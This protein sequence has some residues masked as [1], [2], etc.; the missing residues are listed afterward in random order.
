MTGNSV[1]SNL[2]TCPCYFIKLGTIGREQRE[3]IRSPLFSS[4]G[5]KDQVAPCVYLHV[6]QELVPLSWKCFVCWVVVRRGKS[7]AE[8]IFDD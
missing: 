5:E 1:S 3:I 2:V 8:G 6:E 4:R 7:K